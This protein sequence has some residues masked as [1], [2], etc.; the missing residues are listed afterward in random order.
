V[1]FQ[2]FDHRDDACNQTPDGVWFVESHTGMNY[3]FLE[4]A[5]VRERT[6]QF[7]PMILVCGDSAWCGAVLAGRAWL[8]W[9]LPQAQGEKALEDFILL[10]MPNPLAVERLLP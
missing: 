8:S 10:R 5:L 4:A 7:Q 1:R 6:R 3:E 9:F 2:R